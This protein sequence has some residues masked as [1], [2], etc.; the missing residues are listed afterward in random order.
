MGKENKGYI[1]SQQ[2]SLF[3]HS[4]IIGFG[5]DDF[6]IKEIDRN[7]ANDIIKKN[8]YSK[9]VYMATYLHLGLYYKGELKGVLQLGYAMNPQS[10]GGVVKGTQID[11]YLEL[12]RMWLDEVCPKNTA[13]R[14]IGFAIKYIK[15]KYPKIKW[16][17]SFADER[18]K[19]FG[20]VYQSANF[21]FFGEH[22][23]VFWELDN[24]WYH[25]VQM[26]V[27]RESDRYI[28]NVGGAKFLQ[29]NKERAKSFK[30]RQFR[31]IFFIDKRWKK[32]CLLEEK[33]YPKHGE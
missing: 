8:H 9:K 24:E 11:E 5:V 23:A 15:K 17:Q 30:L 10:M 31:Y 21:D 32:K 22:I 19:R 26:T 14:A 12:N 18:C 25:N 7:I 6:H 4:E 3:G 29:E 1:L 13:S 33:S 2:G 28:R 27:S 16:I 20:V